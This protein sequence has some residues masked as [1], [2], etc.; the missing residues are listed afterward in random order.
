MVAQGEL[1]HMAEEVVDDDLTLLL[2]KGKGV[3]RLGIFNTNT[4]KKKYVHLS[5]I[6]DSERSLK[7]KAGKAGTKEY[8]TGMIRSAILRLVEKAETPMSL[9]PLVWRGVQML[10]DLIHMPKFAR[11]E[12]DANLIQE[13]KRNTLW[14]AYTPPKEDNWRVRPCFVVDGPETAIM[15]AHLQNGTPWP[16]IPLETGKLPVTMRN[17]TVTKELFLANPKRWN[18]MLLPISKAILLG[19]SDWSSN[20]EHLLGDALWAHVQG[21]NY[22]SEDCLL[23]IA[24]AGKQF[25]MRMT[26]YL[27]LWPVLEKIGIET[28]M[29]STKA[30]ESRDFKKRERF[31]MVSQHR[32]DRRFKVTRYVDGDASTSFGIVPETRLPGE[33][34]QFVTLQR[35]DW[36]D[37]LEACSLGGEKDPQ[38]TCSSVIWGLETKNWLNDI[39][40]CIGEQLPVGGEST[41]Q[42]ESPMRA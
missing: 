41:C 8:Q 18:R 34:D 36:E 12:V 15:E 21:Q 29:D 10:G 31:E 30:A 14:F 23:N 3:P 28:V 27:R 32:G 1:D 24:T 39:Y 26:A 19:Y 33:M 7:I 11:S 13:N 4:N 20:G 16:G 2:V 38:Y 9:K 5:W 37:C 40:L 22:R 17:F 6:E 35:E 42:T 25:V